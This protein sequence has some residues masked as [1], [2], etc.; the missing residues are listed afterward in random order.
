MKVIFALI[1]GVL[2]PIISAQTIDTPGGWK[3][4]ITSQGRSITRGNTQILIGN[5]KNL[6]GISLRETLENMENNPVNEIPISSSGGVIPEKVDGAFSVTRQIELNGKP[7]ISL[8]A[9][10]PGLPGHARIMTVTAYRKNVLQ[11][12]SAAGFLEKVC[13]KEPKGPVTN[14]NHDNKNTTSAQNQQVIADNDGSK[15]TPLPKPIVNNHTSYASSSLPLDPLTRIPTT[16][17]GPC[18]KIINEDITKPTRLVNSDKVCDYKLS[19]N[20]EVSSDLTI[21][22]GVGIRV[23]AD[24]SISVT[25]GRII[26]NGTAEN[27][28][29]MDGLTHT[30]GYWKGMQFWKGRESSF[31][32]F[33]M[34]DA[35][36]V[37]P[38]AVCPDVA[39]RVDNVSLSFT[40]SSVSN[41]YV[42]GMRIND[43][44]DLLAFSNNRF[45]NNQRAGLSVHPEHIP[46]MDVATDYSG[47]KFPNATPMLDVL[48]GEQ[49]QGK[50]YRWKKLTAPYHIAGSFRPTGG[51]WKIDP[52]VEIVM[53][54]EA[55][56]SIEGNA[57]VEA[58]GTANDPIVFRGE[59]RKAGYWSG[60]QLNKATKQNTFE[61]VKISDFGNTKSLASKRSAFYLN[62]SRL[63]LKDV[64][65]DNGK[66]SGIRCAESTLFKDG[67][68]VKIHGNVFITNISGIQM[69]SSCK[70]P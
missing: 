1:I 66:G 13:E 12:I 15:N 46:M 48:S 18:A 40:N 27:P 32:H 24:G 30:P 59:Q 55:W 49:T 62:D 41:S 58:I 65:I 7:A 28:I 51:R 25:G 5:W 20:I 2:S 37:C 43:T 67:S 50:V 61:H 42:Y 54:V 9:G 10:C 45:F 6:Q 68:F 11:I 38:R 22:P 14:S 53:D 21:D 47:G 31:N 17:D 4:N 69:E 64:I 8:I 34:A 63:S 70:S 16:G 44:V 60:L 26:A 33:H 36:Q 57:V 39:L 56:I 3:E 23:E 29:V 35:G 19:G 52:G